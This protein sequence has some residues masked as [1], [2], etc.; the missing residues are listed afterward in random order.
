MVWFKWASWPNLVSVGYSFRVGKSDVSILVL[1]ALHPLGKGQ[2][3]GQLL[4]FFIW[5]YLVL[6]HA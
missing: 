5:A 4:K 3:Q 1:E 2:G 6:L